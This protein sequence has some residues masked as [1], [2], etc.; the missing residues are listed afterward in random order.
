MK[1]VLFLAYY[2]PPM[3]GGGVQR[4]AKFCKYLPQYGYHPAVITANSE[5]YDHSDD[6]SLNQEVK[7]VPRHEIKPLTTNPYLKKIIYSDLGRFLNWHQNQWIGA[8]KKA[9]EAAIQDEKPDLICVSVSPYPMANVAEYLSKKF[10]IPWVL[11]MRDP[12]ALDPINCYATK[13]HYYRDK[14]AMKRACQSANAVIMN[15]PD[16]LCAAK[17][18]FPDIEPVK[19]ISITNGWDAEDFKR[20]SYPTIFH[21]ST[22][23]MKLVHTGVF[24][25]RSAQSFVQSGDVNIKSIWKKLKN[26]VKYSP[27]DC[28]MLT[29]TPYYLFEAISILLKQHK[30]SKHDLRIIFAGECTPND[31][32]LAEAH[33]IGEMVNF[34]GY[35]D[36]NRSIQML[37]DADVL[38]LPLHEPQ[39]ML[40]LIVPG[41]TYE[42]LAAQ[43]PILAPIPEGDARRFVQQA[44]LGFVCDPTDV[45]S[46][47]SNL[48]D[49]VKKYR[50]PDGLRINPDVQFIEQY[51]RKKLTEQL[52]CVFDK[53][54]LKSK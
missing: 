4:I 8:A 13:W 20:F 21:N 28:N 54:I 6:L 29:R 39:G 43:R 33:G 31:L 36:H 7:D 37:N 15:T 32:A 38:F 30:I 9:G 24:H 19:F 23:P 1:K 46:I 14:Y 5:Y 18:A 17:A 51:E 44:R 49:L 35:V 47:A 53:V 50:S 41:K 25:T 10:H 12:W 16:S 26:A 11:D 48:L 34:Q 40:P 22:D 45:D 42:Y 3:G 2:F 52:A 27:G